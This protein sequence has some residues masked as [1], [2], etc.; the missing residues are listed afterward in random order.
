[1]YIGNNTINYKYSCLYVLVGNDDI[2]NNDVRFTG[3]VF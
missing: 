2:I 3:D 1:M